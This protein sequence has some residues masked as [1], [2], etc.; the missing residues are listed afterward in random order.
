ME[1]PG[2]L[3]SCSSFQDRRIAE[4][5]SFEQDWWL[6]SMACGFPEGKHVGQT[7]PK[8]AAFSSPHIA[9]QHDDEACSVTHYES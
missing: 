9:L 8:I 7:G 6:M 5:Q 1:H 2:R 4:L 3:P